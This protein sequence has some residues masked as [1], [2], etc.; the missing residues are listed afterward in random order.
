[1]PHVTAYGL[2][3]VGDASGYIDAITGEG[4]SLSFAHALAL[5]EV[6]A[7]RLAAPG[8]LLLARDLLPYARRHHEIGRAYRFFTRLA[9]M[10]SRRP[11]LLE[12]VIPLLRPFPAA[13]PWLL[14]LNQYRHGSSRLNR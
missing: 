12:V 10:I 8:G 4:L 6:A 13:F 11:A 5:A 3:L 14:S 1:V 2:A 9:L 7:P